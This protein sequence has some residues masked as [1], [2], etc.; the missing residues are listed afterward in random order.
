VDLAP[1]EVPRV[2]GVACTRARAA[3]HRD[4]Q[5]VADYRRLRFVAVRG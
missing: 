4:G 2:I 1:A 5:W 3:L